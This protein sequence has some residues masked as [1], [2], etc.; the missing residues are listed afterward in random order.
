MF[1]PPSRRGE[2]KG[3][4]GPLPVAEVGPVL[5][6]THARAAGVQPSSATDRAAMSAKQLFPNRFFLFFF[7]LR[8]TFFFFWPCMLILGSFN[9]RC[10]PPAGFL[11]ARSLQ[12]RAPPPALCASGAVRFSCQCTFIVVCTARKASRHG[13]LPR[14]SRPGVRFYLGS[15]FLPTTRLLCILSSLVSLR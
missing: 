1:A 7:F 2:A 4:G 9:A 12:A 11:L 15:A 13:A 8:R 6:V 5:S 14:P 10:V 3:G